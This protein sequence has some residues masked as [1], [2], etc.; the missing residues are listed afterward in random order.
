MNMF[1]GIVRNT[2]R[3]TSVSC[4]HRI[5]HV[6][7]RKPARWKLSS[8]QSIAVDGICSTVVAHTGHFFDIEYMPETLKKTTAAFFEKGSIVN[9]ERPLK[10][11][12]PIDGHLMQGHVD[13]RTR[14][15]AMVE[16]GRLREIIIALPSAVAKRVALHGSV[17]LNGVSLTVARKRGTTCTVALIPHTIAHTNLGRLSVGDLMNIEADRTAALTENVAHGRVSR[18]AAKRVRKR[19]K[20]R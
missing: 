6:R 20:S 9:L 17:A 16:K 3:V 15:V 11:G 10:Y 7:I 4:R 2:S 13:A 8:G 18:N 12:D 5:Q 19:T 1:T 14:I